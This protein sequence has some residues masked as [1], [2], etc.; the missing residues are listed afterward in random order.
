M[1]KRYYILV[2]KEETDS[3]WEMLF[4]AYYKQDVID[5]RY[6]YDMKG[7]YPTKIV[8]LP[9]DTTAAITAYMIALREGDKK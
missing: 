2:G 1:P 8:I 3:E 6:E 5:E 9:L 4:G 7:Y